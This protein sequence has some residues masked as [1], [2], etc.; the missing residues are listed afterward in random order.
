MSVVV[1]GLGNI[2]KRHRANIRAMCPDEKIIS[3]S[4]SGK[5]AG[6]SLENSDFIV[7]SLEDVALNDVS[8]AVIA[9]PATKHLDHARELAKFGVPLYIEKPLAATT[10]D[11][12][13]LMEAVDGAGIK[14]K[15]GYCLRFMDSAKK[16][17]ELVNS[18]FLG[19]IYHIYIN[20]GQYLPD[21]R[22]GLDYR[23]SV[24]ASKKLGGGALLELSHELDYLQWIFGK[25]RVEYS[26]LSFSKDLQL[27]VEDQVDVVLVGEKKEVAYVHLDFLQ[28]SVQRR[29]EVI[30]ENGR[31]IWDL[32]EDKVSFVTAGEERLLHPP[33]LENR[34]YMYL[35]AME[36]F[37]NEISGKPS[38]GASLVE[39]LKTIE[40]TED[41]RGEK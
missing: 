24:S 7:A 32:V 18:R 17:R 11:C 25:F 10:E 4:A 6:K 23:D 3:V 34:N 38:F 19:D 28:R 35:A 39:A 37:F 9:S 22:V 2:S 27:D 33:K 14:S 30:G 40:L 5:I 12:K 13:R 29:C 36:D 26:R 31:L 20:V 8:F 1:I 41:I 15:V 21:W 16:M